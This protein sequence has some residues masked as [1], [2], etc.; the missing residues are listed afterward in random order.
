MAK[1]EALKS[2]IEA[3]RNAIPELKGVLLAS[4]ERLPIAHSFSNGQDP[5]RVAAMAA[6]AADALPPPGVAVGA[7]NCSTKGSTPARKP[8]TAIF[9]LMTAARRFSRINDE[10]KFSTCRNH[11]AACSKAFLGIS[12]TIS[13]DTGVTP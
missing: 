1:G 2:Q 4:N 3:L 12:P 6:A 13:L 5:N 7:A 10:S 11:S 9:P 8:P